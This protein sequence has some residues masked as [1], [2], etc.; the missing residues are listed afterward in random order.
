VNAGEDVGIQVG[1]SMAERPSTLQG[2]ALMPRSGAALAEEF[3]PGIAGALIAGGFTLC[4]L[5]VIMHR[6]R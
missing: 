5:A 4:M 2:V 6:R 1:F 3:E